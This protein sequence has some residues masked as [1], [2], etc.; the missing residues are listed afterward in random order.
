[1]L[2]RVTISMPTVQVILYDVIFENR[3]AGDVSWLLRAIANHLL[4]HQMG[5]NRNS[6]MDR[7]FYLEKR[8]KESFNSM[9]VY[10]FYNT[11][12]R[13]CRHCDRLVLFRP[14]TWAALSSMFVHRTCHTVSKTN[15]K[16][17]IALCYICFKIV[18]YCTEIR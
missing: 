16:Y 5:L 3:R 1:M 13:L 14:D 18:V 7:I 12:S 2:L 11:I 17:L 15:K 4:A 10:C 9:F 8:R 6:I